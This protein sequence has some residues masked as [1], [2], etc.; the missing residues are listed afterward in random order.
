MASTRNRI[1]LFVAAI[2]LVSLIGGCYNA[3][4]GLYFTSPGDSPVTVHTGQTIQLSIMYRESKGCSSPEIHENPADVSWSVQGPIPTQ[5]QR[6]GV[7]EGTWTAPHTP[8]TYTITAEG[9]DKGHKLMI[10]KVVPTQA[11]QPTEQRDERPAAPAT[12][13]VKLLE[14]GNTLGI[15]QGGKAPTFTLGKPAIVTDLTTYHYMDAGLPSSGTLGLKSSD[16]K[17]YGPWPTK[18]L[19]GQGGK[20]NAFWQATPNAEIPA[21]SYTVVDS[22]PGTWSTNSKAKG[23]GFTTL[24]VQYK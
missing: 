23:I 16:G 3:N 6:T 19:D 5:V 14:T 17:T 21:G 13:P 22:D 2:L 15:H 1:P 10:V 20:K 24:W 11:A 8:G 7:G 9:G 12:A 18:G 4:D